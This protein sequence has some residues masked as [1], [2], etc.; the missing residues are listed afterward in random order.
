[1]DNRSLGRRKLCRIESSEC[2]SPSRMT[3]ATAVTRPLTHTQRMGHLQELK[4]PKIVLVSHR[5]LMR[6]DEHFDAVVFA[7]LK[8]CNHI[9]DVFVVVDS[10]NRNK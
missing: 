4:I 9:V 8:H 7:F 3:G 1:M 2:V 5:I 10:S 6:I